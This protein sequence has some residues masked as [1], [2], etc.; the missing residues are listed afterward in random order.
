MA[1]AARNR[2]VDE[3][4]QNVVFFGSQYG[5]TAEAS[6]AM[7]WKNLDPKIQRDVSRLTDSIDEFSQDLDKAVKYWFLRK[8]YNTSKRNA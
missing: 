5:I 1:D 2:H 3:Y 7:A 8:S 4:V 6:L